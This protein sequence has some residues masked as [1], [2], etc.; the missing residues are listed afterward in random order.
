MISE[1][2][3][4]PQE[5]DDEA[6]VGRLVALGRALSDPIRV[7]MLGMMAGGRGCCSLPDC[8]VPAEDQDAGICVCEFEAYFGMGQ[9]KVSYHMKKLKEAGL[10]HEEKRGRW[11][12]YSLSR[13]AA[14]GLLAET[15]HH[16]GPD[17]EI[18]NG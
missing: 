17:A 10:V 1:N 2:G 18:Q 7:R 16:L 14:H 6:R 5:M 11:S 8:G 12:F 9:S 4:A 3:H 15:A 13:E